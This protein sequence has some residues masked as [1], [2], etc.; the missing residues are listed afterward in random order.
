VSNELSRNQKVNRGYALVLAGGGSSVL[1]VVMLFVSGFG[2]FLLFGVIA[3]LCFLGF[4]RLV[5]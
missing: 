5:S 2:M 3:V 4:R 1:A